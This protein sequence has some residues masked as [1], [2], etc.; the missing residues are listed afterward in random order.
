[1]MN[2]RPLALLLIFLLYQAGMAWRQEMSEGTATMAATACAMPCCQH[3]A[4]HDCGCLQDRRDE[5]PT[6]VLPNQTLVQGRDVL[7]QVIWTQ[8]LWQV[9]PVNRDVEMNRPSG[10]RAHEPMAPA[11]ALTVLHC[12]FLT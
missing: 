5:A 1:M 4:Q 3:L 7:V 8:I 9:D 2:A 11:V 10:C 12:V 6:P